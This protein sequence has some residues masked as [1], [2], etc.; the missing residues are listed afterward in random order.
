MKPEEALA[1]LLQPYIKEHQKKKAQREKEHEMERRLMKMEKSKPKITRTKEMMS[2][3]ATEVDVATVV[4]KDDEPE[5][6]TTFQKA[7]YESN[8]SSDSP[9]GIS[10]PSFSF[11]FV[12]SVD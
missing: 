5:N 3:R 4:V 12:L 9:A 7:S 2:P 1:D 8:S 6:G 11:P 10:A